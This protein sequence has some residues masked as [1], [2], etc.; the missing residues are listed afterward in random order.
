MVT[1]KGDRSVCLPFWDTN[2]KTNSQEQV[3]KMAVKRSGE[4]LFKKYN[5]WSNILYYIV[6][7]GLLAS[8]VFMY[9]SW[10]M[11]SKQFAKLVEEASAQDQGYAIE[12]RKNKDT[13]N[14][15]AE[16]DGESVIQPIKEQ[17]EDGK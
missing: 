2:L 1:K 14:N 15:A 4:G 3:I 7:A 9:K 10:D 13:E 8:I 12:L 11:R 6:I 16:E 17:D 5:I